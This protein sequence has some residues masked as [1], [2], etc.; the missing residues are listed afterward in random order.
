MHN[1]IVHFFVIDLCN[2]EIKKKENFCTK[3]ESKTP[4]KHTHGKNKQKEIQ[5]P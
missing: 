1:L 3:N 4:Q 2:Q 5:R